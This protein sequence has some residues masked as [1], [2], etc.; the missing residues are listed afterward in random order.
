MNKAVVLLILCSLFAYKVCGFTE[1]NKPNHV[2]PCA[3]KIPGTSCIASPAGVSVWFSFN[4]G[5]CRCFDYSEE[6]IVY[7]PQKT[8]K[9]ILL[10]R[11][12]HTMVSMHSLHFNPVGTLQTSFQA[13]SKG[14]DKQPSISMVKDQDSEKL[15]TDSSKPTNISISCLSK[16]LQKEVPSLL[17]NLQ[18][19]LCLFQQGKDEHNEALYKDFLKQL[20]MVLKEGGCS[21]DEVLGTTNILEQITDNAGKIADRLVYEI[22]KTADDLKITGKLLNFVCKLLGKT[23]TSLSKVLSNINLN[24]D[25]GLKGITGLLG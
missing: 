8:C 22:L 2:Q 19:L 10:C 25:L 9:S 23:L 20:N 15:V 21:L 7:N 17:L 1:E 16:L 6:M 14:Q 12:L 18:R 3:N 13:Q 4:N 11:M 24:L 5:N